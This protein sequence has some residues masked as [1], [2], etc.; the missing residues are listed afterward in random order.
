ML[1]NGKKQGSRP[2]ASSGDVLG[3]VVL[4]P[5]KVERKW[6][7]HYRVLSEIKER[8]MGEKTA[9]T[10]TA[11]DRVPSFSEHMADAATDT[12]D[13]DWALAALSSTQSLL[14]EIEEALNRIQNGTY[15]V[16]E[17]TGNPIEPARLKAIPWTRFSAEAQAQIE[18]R[19]Q[20][21]R[22]QLGQL[23]SYDKVVQFG[24]AEEDPDEAPSAEQREAA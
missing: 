8:L 19:G 18:T 23:G 7:E 12:Y 5:P 15:G 11:K 2:R 17:L 6:A 24:D 14:Y 13:R 10:Q 1:K 22:F 21:A 4:A 16:C 20:S 3:L 9:R